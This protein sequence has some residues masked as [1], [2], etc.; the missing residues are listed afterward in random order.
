MGNKNFNEKQNGLHWRGLLQ[1]LRLKR[2]LSKLSQEMVSTWRSTRSRLWSQRVKGT[3]LLQVCSRFFSVQEVC[4]EGT[5]ITRL[6]LQMLSDSITT[7]L[8]FDGSSKKS[9][10]PSLN[11]MLPF[12]DDN[13][14]WKFDISYMTFI[15]H[16]WLSYVTFC[17][18]PNI[19]VKMLYGSRMK[20]FLV[21]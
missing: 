10:F 17:N 15:Y 2:R 19:L 11:I 3:I 1:V 18:V 4:S 20:S 12:K 7:V 6:C 5:Y 14:K 8:P 21:K 9:W 16:I 13:K